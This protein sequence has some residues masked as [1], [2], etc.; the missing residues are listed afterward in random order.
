MGPKRIPS[1]STIRH[2]KYRC[3]VVQDIINDSKD[4]QLDE[5][6]TFLGIGQ[7]RSARLPAVTSRA[8]F[9][10]KAVVLKVAFPGAGW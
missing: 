8:L 1:P 3:D 4:A 7:N 2:L 5:R 6:D 10:A 9:L